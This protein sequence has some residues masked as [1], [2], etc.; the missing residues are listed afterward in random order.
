[1]APDPVLGPASSSPVAKTLDENAGKGDLH[2]QDASDDDEACLQRMSRRQREEDDDEEHD[3]L[4]LGEDAEEVEEYDEESADPSDDQD[5]TEDDDESVARDD[6]EHRAKAK[7]LRLV[8]KGPEIAAPAEDYKYL[9]SPKPFFK[10]AAPTFTTRPMGVKEYLKKALNNAYAE[11]GAFCYEQITMEKDP[12][13]K[14]ERGAQVA[15][16]G[17]RSKL[18]VYKIVS[19]R[20]AMKDTGVDEVIITEATRQVH[21]SEW[22]QVPLIDLKGHLCVFRNNLHIVYRACLTCECRPEPLLGYKCTNAKHVDSKLYLR[23]K[24]VDDMLDF[25]DHEDATHT[26]H[27][28]RLYSFGNCTN[29]IKFFTAIDELRDSFTEKM[30]TSDARAVLVALCNPHNRI[31]VNYSRADAVPDVGPS[32]LKPEKI[33]LHANQRA[34]LQNLSHNLEVIHGPPGTGKSTC[35]RSLIRDY[36]PCSESDVVLITA[37]QNKAIEVVSAFLCD[38]INDMDVAKSVTPMIVVGSPNNPSLGMV[39]RGLTL[40]NLVELNAQVISARTAVENFQSS[41][42]ALT[43]QDMKLLTVLQEA[44]TRSREEARELIIE[45]AKIVLGTTTEILK[46]HRRTKLMSRIDFKVTTVL[47]DE[48]SVVA[49]HHMAPLAL[50]PN[51][52]RVICMGDIN[53][54]DPFTHRSIERSFE[55]CNGYLDRAQKT[56]EQ[57]AAVPLLDVQF[58]MQKEIASFVSTSFYH[59]RIKSF[60]G[61]SARAAAPY[62]TTLWLSGLYVLAY[63]THHKFT[64]LVLPFRD[65]SSFFFDSRLVPKPAELHHETSVKMSCINCSEVAHVLE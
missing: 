61:H 22:R 57:Q 25:P 6:G 47:V 41:K 4:L 27:L 46:L 59:G 65:F 53:Q 9:T 62:N 43:K 50:F 31:P 16:R 60:E 33:S 11:Y 20:R 10:K 14:A 18:D 12:K 1:V 13:E 37:S 51:I 56:L 30:L 2:A 44:L 28:Q 42:P 29:Y 40:G 54:L 23:M 19:D 21:G 38:Y 52:K 48:A 63:D 5:D 35:I 17:W 49:E 24:L 55:S 34:V 15:A 58:R 64:E 8:M 36:L 26:D 7:V 32:V 39:A 3:R 45:S